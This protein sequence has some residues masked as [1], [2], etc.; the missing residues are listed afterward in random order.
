MALFYL[1]ISAG[2]LFTAL[3]NQ[4]I[5]NP[6]GTTILV[7]ASY[8]LFFAGFM[9]LVALIFAIYMRFYE[10][11]HI[12]QEESV[13]MKAVGTFPDALS[14][15]VK[16]HCLSNRGMASVKNIVSVV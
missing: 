4:V 5:Q 2:N 16:L 6:D 14:L 3:V 8:H 15:A 7:G 10:E 13:V 1:S 11:Q 9:G 12:I